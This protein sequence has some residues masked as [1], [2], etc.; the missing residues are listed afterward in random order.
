MRLPTCRFPRFVDGLGVR[1]HLFAGARH[2]VDPLAVLEDRGDDLVLGARDLP[3]ARAA[4]TE[5][6][7]LAHPMARNGSGV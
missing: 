6:S 3:A 7:L 2:V 4:N 5:Q 1:E